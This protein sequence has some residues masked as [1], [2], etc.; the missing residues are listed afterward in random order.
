MFI[1]V[2]A[3]S[4]LLQAYLFRD[5][6]VHPFDPCA[7]DRSLCPEE[8]VDSLMAGRDSVVSRLRMAVEDAKVLPLPVRFEME[9]QRS[10]PRIAVD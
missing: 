10:G 8:A 1:V 3:A 5:T 4:L 2:V 7:A 6:R 9:N